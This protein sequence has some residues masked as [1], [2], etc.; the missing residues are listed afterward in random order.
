MKFKYTILRFLCFFLLSFT[1]LNLVGFSLSEEPTSILKNSV[2]IPMEDGI[3][4]SGDLYLPGAQGKF[5]VILIRTP[6]D[7]GDLSAVGE[8]FASARYAVLIQDV[9]GQGKSE[10]AFYPFMSEKK[11]GLDTLNW[12]DQQSW[13]NGKV[14]IW[15]VSYL[16]YSGFVVLPYQHKSVKAFVSSSGFA[17]INKL[18]FRGG[19]FRLMAQLTWYMSQ[20]GKAQLPPAEVRSRAMVPI[21]RTTPLSKFFAGNEDAVDKFEDISTEFSKVSTPI[22]FV[23]GW[24][25]YIYRNTLNA[26]NR[27]KINQKERFYHKL[28]IGPWFHNQELNGGTSV[29]D[30]DFGQEAEMNLQKFLRLSLRWFDYWL[31]NKDD[32]I[33]REAPVEVFVMGKNQWQEESQWP[34][35]SIE[36][37]KWYLSSEKG[38]NSIDGDGRLSRSAPGQESF[39]SFTFDPSDPVPTV[40]GVNMHYFPD[41]LGIKD[42][43]EVEKRKDVLVYTSSVLEKSMEIAGPL[44][45]VLYS[46]TEGVD[47]DFTAKLVQVRPDGYARIIEDGIIRGR[48]RKS[49]ETPDFLEPGEVYEFEID[50]GYTAIS[51]PE[52]SRLRVEISSSNFPKYDRN[53]N[54]E[55][56]P[57]DA[58]EFKKVEQKI[59]FSKKHPSRIIL[60]VRK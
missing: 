18:L 51:L 52:G 4:L 50:L 29:G 56:E 20:V 12:I 8:V 6:Y 15:G 43:T 21:F 27:I 39:D 32:G 55:V 35:A 49:L 58:V 60:P 7:K 36:F 11:D 53:S 42:Q 10:G 24:H 25:D 3:K 17:D 45:V 2:S 22:L 30:E 23:T 9:R 28:M 37:Q 1:A 40:G 26:Y 16:A 54:T 48:Y 57:F 46:S 31:K 44:K 19:A 47:T 34:P 14:G 59:F 41:N 33:S 38:A 5:P 13:S